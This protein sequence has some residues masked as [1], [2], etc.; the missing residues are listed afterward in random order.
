MR[1]STQSQTGNC[2]CMVVPPPESVRTDDSKDDPALQFRRYAIDTA[3]ELRQMTRRDARKEMMLDVQE[4]VERD[5]V[6]DFVAQCSRDVM[7]AVAMVMDR[8]HSEECSQA[9]PD[10][11]GAHVVPERA[12]VEALEYKRNPNGTQKQLSHD[13]C[14]QL[15]IALSKRCHVQQDGKGGT[16]QERAPRRHVGVPAL[17]VFF[18]QGES[19]VSQVVELNGVHRSEH[20]QAHDPEHDIGCTA[21]QPQ[22]GVEGIVDEPQPCEEKQE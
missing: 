21:R 20:R 18:A 2:T 11:H 15:A 14:T 12:A 10:G 6:L 9:L 13:S 7:G 5:S 17:D 19:M 16:E 8:P 4:H 3:R 1:P 22:R